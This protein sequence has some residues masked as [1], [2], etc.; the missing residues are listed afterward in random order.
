MLCISGCE[1][2]YIDTDINC[3]SEA[4]IKLNNLTYSSLM[5]STAVNFVNRLKLNLIY[6]FIYSINSL[7]MSF[8]FKFFHTSILSNSCSLLTFSY[9]RSSIRYSQ[10]QLV[11]EAVRLN[12]LSSQPSV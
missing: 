2:L 7:T 1:K 12:L 8:I 6:K 3:K 9:L 11:S 5:T 10:F 4:Q